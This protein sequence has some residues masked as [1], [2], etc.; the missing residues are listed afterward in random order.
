[1]GWEH[2]RELT[3]PHAWSVSEAREGSTPT[4][5]ILTGYS[6]AMYSLGRRYESGLGAAKNPREAARCYAKAAR[7][8]HRLRLHGN[9]VNE[10]VQRVLGHVP[11]LD[12]MVA[13]PAAHHGLSSQRLIHL[14]HGDQLCADQQMPKL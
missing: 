8:G 10:R 1:M 11:K 7:L 6:N 3:A 9:L 14:L 12:H 2:L 4:S 13:E 5:L